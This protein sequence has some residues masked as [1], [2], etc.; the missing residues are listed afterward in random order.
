MQF[1][2]STASFASDLLVSWFVGSL[3][4]AV[5]SSK[6]HVEMQQMLRY[7]LA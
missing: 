7:L 6:S 5:S 2:L 4:L 1:A 3:N